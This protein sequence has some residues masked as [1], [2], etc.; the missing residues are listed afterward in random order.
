MKHSCAV[1][2]GSNDGNS[3]QILKSVL[4]KFKKDNIFQINKISS[5][6]LTEPVET[7]PQPY[8]YNLVVTGETSCA[9]QFL[10]KYF[11]SLEKEFGRKRIRPKDARTIDI[12]LLYFE[13]II[14]KSDFLTLPHPSLL[15]RRCVLIPLKEVA[16]K[17][18]HPETKMSV[19]QILFKI[20]K[21]GE[22][23]KISGF[24]FS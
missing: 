15:T 8:F 24:T 14:L 4:Q 21:N 20:G 5:L 16:P 10:L 12:D 1:S 3:I 6:Y 11:L 23:N 17:W 19:S 18:R 7:F 2:L 22:V 13:K 9:P